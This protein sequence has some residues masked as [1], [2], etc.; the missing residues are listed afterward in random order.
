M[1]EPTHTIGLLID[2]PT[3]RQLLSAFLREQGHAVLAALPEDVLLRDGAGISLVIADATSARQHWTTL[4][5]FRQQARDT[6]LPCLI[7]LSPKELSGAWLEAGFDDVLRLPLPK[8]ELAARVEAFL[9]LHDQ[10]VAQVRERAELRTS[11]ERM[12]LLTR[13][14]VLGQEAERKR[15]SGDMHDE[16]GQTLAVLKMSLSLIGN[17]LPLPVETLRR[18][19]TEAVALTETTI[20]QMRRIARDLRP[21]GLDEDGLNGALE[22]LCRNFAQGTRLAVS[23]NFGGEEPALT[24]EAR[25]SLYR[26][27]Q[28]ALTNVARHA[29]ARKV[30]VSLDADESGVH[31][32]VK[33]DGQGFVQLASQAGP[34][35]SQGMGL[36][37]MQER[38][39]ML[40]G[41]LEI[42]SQPG[43]GTRL[44]AHIPRD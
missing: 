42:E 8:R 32:S 17:D 4:S 39:I 23:C 11:H 29:D 14:V 43:R 36:L 38:I 22:T 13:Q 7:A 24:D 1:A 35:T 9:R 16:L 6:F 30:R 5:A 3:D 25:I 41:R 12:R 15:L 10:S 2:R 20:V 28:E 44:V 31:L 18:R 34:V 19:I 37:S 27:V 21:L 26:F 40:G 33:D